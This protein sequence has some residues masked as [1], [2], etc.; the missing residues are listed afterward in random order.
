MRKNLVKSAA[1]ILALSLGSVS[2]AGLLLEPSL[3]YES[4]TIKCESSLGDCGATGTATVI[5]ARIGYKMM[6][7]WIAL[8]ADM[9]TGKSKGD[10]ASDDF[11][12]TNLGVDIGVDLPVMFRAW[13][14]YA[15]TNDMKLKPSSGDVTFKGTATKIG[16]AFT[17]LPFVNI[18][19]NYIM[20]KYT[21]LDT[22]A[23]TF[24]VDTVYSKFDSTR[25]QIGVSMPFNF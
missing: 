13:I 23:G 22:S 6:M 7:P 2:Q 18:Y 3:A 10:S 15:F 11:D 16:A 17:G 25:V 21:K 4:G 9:A 5:G 1:V 14:G 12:R 20:D 19:V 24:D 8:S